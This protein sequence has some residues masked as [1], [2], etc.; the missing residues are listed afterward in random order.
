MQGSFPRATKSHA[1]SRDTLTDNRLQSYINLLVFSSLYWLPKYLWSFPETIESDLMRH[2]ISISTAFI[3]SLFVASSVGAED[4]KPAEWLFVHTA[5]TAEMTSPTTLVMPVERD[6]FAF[7]DRS[8][9]RHAYLTAEQFAGLW[10]DDKGDS[11]KADPPKAVFTFVL[12]DTVREAEVV[13]T[14][15]AATT[16][17][18]SL[19]YRVKFEVGTYL[20]P[21]NFFK[22]AALYIDSSPFRPID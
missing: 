17:G 8:N 2:L 21:S 11:F 10:A 20:G 16:D 19:V 18:K 1:S 14:G 7:T 6:I 12:G 15:A 3:M 22:T 5:Q 4:A 13:I 9:R